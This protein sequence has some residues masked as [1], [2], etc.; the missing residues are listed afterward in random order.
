MQELEGHLALVDAAVLD[1]NLEKRLGV[2]QDLHVFNH[3]T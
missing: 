2:V 3:G 1:A